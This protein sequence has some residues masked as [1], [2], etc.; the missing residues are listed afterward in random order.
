MIAKLRIPDREEIDKGVVDKSEFGSFGLDEDMFVIE[1]KVN[2][3]G[4]VNR[5]RYMPQNHFVI[6]TKGPQA[7]VLIFAYDKHESSDRSGICK[8]ELR[9]KGHEKEGYG[10]SW[11]LQTKGQLLSSADDKLI[12]L[13]DV[14]G[15]SKEEKIL[16]ALNKFS[17]HTKIVEDVQWHPL[18]GSIFGSVGDDKR[19]LIW[20]IREFE[21]SRPRHSVEAHTAEVNCLSFNN[22]SEYILCTG[23]ADRVLWS[24]HEETVLGSCGSD[25]RLN[26]WDLSK[27][28]EEQTAED[29]EDGPPELLFRHGGHTA[30]ISDFSWHLEKPWLI[31]SVAEDNVFQA[32][33]V[34]KALYSEEEP[35]IE[36]TEL[37]A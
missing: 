11:N 7:D 33:E 28:G 24:P 8:P 5:A 23:S 9:L 26:I 31:C 6:A 34:A 25:K 14:Q 15:G 17:G 30:K 1:Q 19:L 27:I 13:W 36:A 10:L 22:F 3:E 32:W 37:E 35:E 16:W 12:C 18:H 29:A 20:D 2:H 4:E 21:S